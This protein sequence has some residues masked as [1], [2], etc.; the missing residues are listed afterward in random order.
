MRKYS[1][2]NTDYANVESE[3]KKIEERFGI[4]ISAELEMDANGI[5]PVIKFNAK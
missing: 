1:K 3:I 4:E 2:I 5:Y